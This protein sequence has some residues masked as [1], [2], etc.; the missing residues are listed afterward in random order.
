MK[1]PRPVSHS[2]CAPKYSLPR[3]RTQ[4]VVAVDADRRS[5]EDRIAEARIATV[6]GVQIRHAAVEFEAPADQRD[7]LEFGTVDVRL[8]GICDRR[9]VVDEAVDLNVVVVVDEGLRRSAADVVEQ[10]A[11]API[12]YAQIVSGS[13]APSHSATLKPPAL[14]PFDALRYTIDVFGEVV[15]DDARAGRLVPIPD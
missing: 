1:R 13:N 6:L 5:T 9:G 2:Y 10:V 15:V 11:F 7:E 12:S 8:G 3:R 14:K 4:R